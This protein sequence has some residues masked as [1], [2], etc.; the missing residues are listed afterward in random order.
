MPEFDTPQPILA[1]IELNVGSVRIAA[2]DRTDTVVEV[3]PG[4]RSDP[5]DVATAEQARIA[6]AAGE[7]VVAAPKPRGFPRGGGAVIID[8]EVPSG[9]R[10]RGD[11]LAADFHCVGRLG[12]CRLTTD[13]GHIDLEEAG[14]LHLTSI[15]GNVG[16]GHAVGDVEAFAEGGDV[17]I[18]VV[19]GTVRLNRTKGD[20]RI[21]EAKG[22]VHVHADSGDLHIGK[23]HG[24]V[25]ARASQGDIRVDEAVRGPLVLETACGK[26]DIGITVGMPALLDL[27]SHVGTVYRALD[28]LAPE[29]CS[30]SPDAVRVHAHA[31]IGDIAVR[32]ATQTQNDEYWP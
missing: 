32:R 8:I 29:V 9:S 15:L 23:A 19:D 27:D 25:E 22:D 7:L 21:G 31:I 13:C 20:A 5:C 10:I 17:R 12:E 4:D 6:F 24:S 3:R 18:R 26:V 30:D 14:P 28:L 11:A 2:S 1:T 16:V